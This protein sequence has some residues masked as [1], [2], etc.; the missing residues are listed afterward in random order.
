[1]P[2]SVPELSISPGQR[3]D[4]ILDREPGD[5]GGRFVRAR[6]DQL[7]FNYRWVGPLYF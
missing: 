7:F 3:Y 1:M 4:V 2:L 5:T 6:M